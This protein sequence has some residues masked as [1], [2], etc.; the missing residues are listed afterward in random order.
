LEGNVLIIFEMCHEKNF[1]IEKF[2]VLPFRFD[3]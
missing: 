3:S 1:I 2:L